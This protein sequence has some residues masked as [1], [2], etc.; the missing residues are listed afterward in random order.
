MAL[1]NDPDNFPTSKYP[2][3]VS[4]SASKLRNLAWKVVEERGLP[5]PVIPRYLV[6]IQLSH[7]TNKLYFRTE[8]S[9]SVNATEMNSLRIACPTEHG[10]LKPALIWLRSRVSVP[11]S[12]STIELLQS[13]MTPKLFMSCSGG[14][15]NMINS[16][17]HYTNNKAN[18][19]MT[20]SKTNFTFEVS[21]FLVI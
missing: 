16:I 9:Y 15:Q 2:R 12:P 5:T 3:R 11:F 14:K 10:R 6:Q 17:L 8:K 18:I 21:S 19:Q 7:E 13:E 20:L 1:F 4:S